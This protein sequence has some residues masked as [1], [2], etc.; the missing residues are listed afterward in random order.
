MIIL[1][2]SFFQINLNS[3]CAFSL[4][5]SSE[6]KDLMPRATHS[7][8]NVMSDDYKTIIVKNQILFKPRPN[9]QPLNKKNIVDTFEHYGAVVQF[10]DLSNKIIEFS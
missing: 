3:F 4:F 5:F 10:S 6:S 1:F 7:D 2:T 8:K 9:R